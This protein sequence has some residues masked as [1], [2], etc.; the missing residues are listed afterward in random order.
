MRVRAIR[1]GFY[2]GS[3]RRPGVE[4][5]MPEADKCMPRW[6]QPIAEPKAVIKSD[7]ERA[8]DAARAT[9][10]PKRAGVAALRDERGFALDLGESIAENAVSLDTEK[11]LDEIDVS[12]ERVETAAERNQREIDANDSA[13]LV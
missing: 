12:A 13:E 1:Q 6:V 9:A 10:G 7:E 3:R 2:R 4:F 11:P 8:I 5:D